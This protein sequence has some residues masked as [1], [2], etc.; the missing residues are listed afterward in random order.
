[1]DKATYREKRSEYKSTI[2]EKKKQ[3]KI[4][5]HQ[6]LLDNKRNS[7]KFW[8]TV[9]SVRRRRKKQP[10]IDIKIW[11]NHFQTILG[12]VEKHDRSQ[13]Q[14]KDDV[15]G[16]NS[17]RFIPELD[18][19][20]TEQEVRQAIKNLKTGK[21][22]G[23]D[24]ICADFLKYAEHF[25]VPFLTKLFNK[26][27]YTSYFPLDSCKSVIIP[28]FKKGKDSNPDNYRGISLLSI[29]SKVFTAILNKRLYAWAENEEKI[30]KEQAGFRKGTQPLITSLR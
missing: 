25:V 18:N 1:M 6:A 9:R 16:S 3:Y 10:E 13:T 23:L 5:I 20:I 14:A 27:Y 24:N 17:E 22:S 12:Q 28:L 15:Q 21:T 29:V 30:S 11:Q 8:E 26:L 19:P 4:T 7:N 2:S